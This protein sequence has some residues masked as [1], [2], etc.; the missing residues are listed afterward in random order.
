MVFLLQA[1]S[2]EC[3]CTIFDTTKAAGNET[4]FLGSLAFLEPLQEAKIMTMDLDC[5]LG[6]LKPSP[7][8]RLKE[9]GQAN[10][11]DP[12]RRVLMILVSPDGLYGL[13]RLT[14]QRVGLG[15]VYKPP[16][17]EATSFAQ[18]Y[19]SLTYWRS[20]PNGVTQPD[21]L[22]LHVCSESGV[23]PFTDLYPL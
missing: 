16:Y 1:V 17:A 10:P 8:S 15:I 4:I 14:D 2:H 23:A 22:F 11:S 3:Y 5:V 12:D 7:N 18:A 19:A 13:Q 6:W 20:T 9:E 21:C